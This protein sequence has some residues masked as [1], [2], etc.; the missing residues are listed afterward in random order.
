MI[1]QRERAVEALLSQPTIE[2]AAREV[3]IGERTLLRWLADPAFQEAYR[4]AKREL[5]GAATARLRAACG[6][7]VEVLDAIANAPD[8]PSGARVTAARA[9]L[10]LALRAHELEDLEQRLSRL[11]EQSAI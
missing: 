6:R 4:K 5:L 8:K 9:I 3:G 2:K 7:A 11:E 10:E 1:R